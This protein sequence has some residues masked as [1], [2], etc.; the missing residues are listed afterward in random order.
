LGRER[1]SS[2]GVERVALEVGD[3]CDHV[4][5]RVGVEHGGAGG[6]RRGRD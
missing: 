2:G 3:G 1:R 5:V 4:E 6:E